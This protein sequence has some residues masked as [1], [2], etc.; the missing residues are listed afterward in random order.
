MAE[1]EVAFSERV[2][3]Q[4][5][6][7]YQERIE[8]IR[9]FIGG[10]GP[11]IGFLITQ[12]GF[13]GFGTSQG[14]IAFSSAQTVKPEDVQGQL[15]L[16]SED[17]GRPLWEAID[18]RTKQK[19][20]PDIQIISVEDIDTYN[21]DAVIST[22][23]ANCDPK[24]K[25]SLPSAEIP[26]WVVCTKTAAYVGTR[27]P[28]FAQ[29]EFNIFTPS[30]AAIAAGFAVTEVMR[31]NLLIRPS[32]L[33]SSELEMRYVIQQ[34]GILEK[35]QEAQK[36][37]LGLPFNV[38][39][40]IGGEMLRGT[41]EEYTETVTRYVG[42]NVEETVRVDPDRIILHCIF[43]KASYLTRLLFNQIE[44]LDEISPDMYHPI[45]SLF[46]SPLAET[47]VQEKNDQMIILDK[48]IEVP[49][50][51]EDKTI[52]FLGVGGIGSWTTT[53]FNLSNTKNCTLILNDHDEQVEEHNLNR[54]ILFTK[55]SLGKPKALAAQKKL[56]EI[57]S[58]N[59][60]V[61]LPFELEIGAVNS[62]ILKDTMSL[63]EYELRQANPQY[64]EGTE[65]PIDIVRE[66]TVVAHELS[67]SD[68][69]ICGPDN[70]RT[71][72]IST[73]IGKLLNIPVINAGAERFEGKIDLFEPIG[74]CY[75]CRY[76]EESKEHREVISC[77][78]RIPIP[79]IVTTIGTIG[80]MQAT[81]ALAHLADIQSELVHFVQYY[82]RYQILAK[83][84][85]GGKCHHKRKSNC[86]EHLNLLPEE[87]P[88]AFFSTTQDQ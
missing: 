48:D 18:E 64:I 78:G 44:V 14:F 76:G 55:E 42:G 58:N 22:R 23:S 3:R 10:S 80:G 45:D 72:Y 32:E 28:L 86:P 19:I 27:K 66:E 12:L 63:E 60:L 59:N 53:L 82:P 68:I 16:E 34:K 85:P 65:I 71:R 88:F 81:V 7:V 56:R 51:L 73:V 29:S 2:D 4:L 69:L 37:H 40:K 31:R 21:Y 6:L 46:F 38:R 25:L 1:Y 26:I 17:I 67:Q 79:S 20:A 33:L 5:G 36:K 87:N 24:E 35:C 15:L 61:S 8:D 30:L 74:D 13:L 47:Q 39:L 62:I 75:V 50:S 43:P 77:T 49:L 9:I 83:C 54:Q 41:I 11:I 84:Q 70:I 57:N 52:Y